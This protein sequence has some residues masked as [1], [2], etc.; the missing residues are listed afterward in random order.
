M[1]KRSFVYM[2]TNRPKGVIYTGL[3]NNLLRRIEE[4][5]AGII[6]GFTQDYN[7]KIL[8][9]YEIHEDITEAAKRE[10]RIKDWKRDWKINLIERSNPNWY[11][12]HEDL[13]K[14]WNM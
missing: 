14:K 4:H 10:R 6:E 3:T 13:K 12:L 1:D 2:V 5:K 11:D 9:Y 8:V 7:A